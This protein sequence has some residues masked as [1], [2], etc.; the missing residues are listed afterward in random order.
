MPITLQKPTP[1]PW[2]L[3]PAPGAPAFPWERLIQARHPHLFELRLGV[4]VDLAHL[5]VKRLVLDV[6][7]ALVPDPLGLVPCPGEEIG[8]AHV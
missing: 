2:G 8:R 5:A 7:A 6:D 4:D 3:H 1:E